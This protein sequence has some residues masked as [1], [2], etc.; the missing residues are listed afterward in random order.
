MTFILRHIGTLQHINSLISIFSNKSVFGGHCIVHP[1][2]SLPGLETGDH[3]P[4][5]RPSKA[6]AGRDPGP[7]CRLRWSLLLLNNFSVFLLHSMFCWPQSAGRRSYFSCVRP[8]EK[9]ISAFKTLI[10]EM[11]C[12]LLVLQVNVSWKYVSESLSRCPEL[13]MTAMIVLL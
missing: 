12:H 6:T 8:H 10:S 2:W 11:I 7:D 9:F 1:D 13:G 3:N 4:S 5:L